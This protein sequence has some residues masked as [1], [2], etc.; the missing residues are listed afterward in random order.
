P[1]SSPWRTTWVDRVALLPEAQVVVARDGSNCTLEAA[2][3]L[4]AIHL[5]PRSTPSLRGDV[6]R[7]L[8]DQTGTRS[9]DRVYWSNQN[10]RIMADIALEA[11]LQP[12]LWGTFVF[13]R[14]P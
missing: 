4:A 6:G 11:R 7:V 10:T 1:F 3:P 13:E 14:G 5:D 8:S 12:N 2:V 9:V